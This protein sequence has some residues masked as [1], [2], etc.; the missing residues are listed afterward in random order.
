M[1]TVFMDYIFSLSV[2][3]RFFCHLPER[4]YITDNNP[5]TAPYTPSLI[6]TMDT[7]PPSTC[8]ENI[9]YPA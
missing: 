1:G 5:S 9:T 2:Y 4:M 7:G 3:I 6:H 8:A